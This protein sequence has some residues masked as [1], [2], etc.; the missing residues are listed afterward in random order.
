[1]ASF[2]IELMTN[3]LVLGSLYSRFFVRE[4]KWNK[5]IKKF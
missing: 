3:A 4:S 1:M 5:G 2:N